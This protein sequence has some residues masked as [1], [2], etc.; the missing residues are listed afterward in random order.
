METK[1]LIIDDTIIGDI[2]AKCI[3]SG[4]YGKIIN[5]KL[6]PERNK[7]TNLL[8]QFNIFFSNNK[9]TSILT[10]LNSE[11]RLFDSILITAVEIAE[12]IRL[13]YD[14]QNSIILFYS[15]Y[16]KESLSFYIDGFSN[17]I[18]LPGHYYFKLPI[19][20]NENFVSWE[21]EAINFN[22]NK[23]CKE[24][25]RNSIFAFRSH[26][27]SKQYLKDFK[28]SIVDKLL[29]QVSD[30]CSIIPQ[31]YHKWLN[32][33]ILSL[34]SSEISEL[35]GI[36]MQ[37]EFKSDLEKI[38]SSLK[39]METTEKR[40][41]I[42]GCA[43]IQKILIE[44]INRSIEL[45][46]KWSNIINYVN[47]NQ[48]LL[49][50]ITCLQGVFKE[51]WSE[52]FYNLNNNEYINLWK[53]IKSRVSL[54]YEVRLLIEI[55]LWRLSIWVSGRKSRTLIESIFCQFLDPLI[56]KIERDDYRGASEIFNSVTLS[57]LKITNGASLNSIFAL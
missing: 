27:V 32:M 39:R 40:R 9:N 38:N 11:F 3:S 45:N 4:G 7:S 6:L 8:E 12:E 29:P 43:E 42:K 33:K 47:E 17:I 14:M 49:K 51:I 55:L 2:L 54:Y 28:H 53:E 19:R 36:N 25:A 31:Y 52:N 48:K 18:E 44:V 15:L 37:E 20:L 30:Y 50:H 35:C 5:V 16:K 34:F 21:K 57:N 46:G 22:L 10:F 1:V 56:E 13:L 41:F 26:Q 24:L 23:E